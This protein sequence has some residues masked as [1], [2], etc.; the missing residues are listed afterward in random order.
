MRALRSACRRQI[1]PD[2]RLPH[3]VSAIRGRDKVLLAA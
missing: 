1:R 2:K 3:K